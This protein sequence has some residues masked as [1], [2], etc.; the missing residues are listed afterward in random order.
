M[1]PRDKSY[2]SPFR[3]HLLE[4]MLAYQIVGIIAAL[5]LVIG[6]TVWL[7]QSR[8]PSF[9]DESAA[10]AVVLDY[11]DPGELS[12]FQQRQLLHEILENAIAAQGGRVF[13]DRLL[14]VKKVG[15]LTQRDSVMQ[16]NY[17]FKRP[18]RV[19]YRLEHDERG[20]RIGFDGAR[21]WIQPF[22]SGRLA[23]A[24]LLDAH[25][26]TSLTLTS[27]LATP[28]VLFFDESQHM[29][30]D[31]EA[32]V[33][34]HLCYVL[35]Y[36]GPLRASQ[37]FYID[38]ESHILRKR[39]RQARFRGEDHTLVEVT[40]RDFRNV[41]GVEVPHYEEVRFDGELQTSFVIDEYILNPGILDEFFE[42]PEQS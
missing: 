18:N 17:S 29:T 11:D 37:R 28:A 8:Q 6:G 16:V 40:Y 13:V 42:M 39:T 23:D 33:D 10:R 2:H 31:G 1:P 32:M 34:G 7:L 3:Q 22:A 27:E 38:Q 25:D 4:H 19:R 41:D 35:A 9:V 30:F 24:Q 26:A 12:A 21:A 20:F 36:S 5:I 15:T 14:T